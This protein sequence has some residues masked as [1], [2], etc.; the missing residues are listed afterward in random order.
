VAIKFGGSK[1]TEAETPTQEHKT[2]EHK[3]PPK[4]P[5]KPKQ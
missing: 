4:T 1:A 5:S 2:Q 3:T